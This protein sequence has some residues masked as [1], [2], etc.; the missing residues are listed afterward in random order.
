MALD[1]VSC[2]VTSLGS[3]MLFPHSCS[4]FTLLYKVYVEWRF[5][6]LLL[7]HVSAVF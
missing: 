2:Y 3:E 6:S 4:R 1:L 7:Q 5:L